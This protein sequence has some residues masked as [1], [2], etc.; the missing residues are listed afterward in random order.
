MVKNSL[1]IASRMLI[2]KYLTIILSPML[3]KHSHR[4]I[5]C[6]HTLIICCYLEFSSKNYIKNNSR[7]KLLVLN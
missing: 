1:I 2:I 3:T 5:I 4:S 6:S 7:V